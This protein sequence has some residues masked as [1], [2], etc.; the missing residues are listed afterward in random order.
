MS[1]AKRCLALLGLPDG[2]CSDGWLGHLAV[3]LT[4]TAIMTDDFERLP[5]CLLAFFTY[6]G[7][8]S[9]VGFTL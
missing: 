3:I 4:C 6:S 9:F 2:S 7:F 1:Q 8:E 5:M